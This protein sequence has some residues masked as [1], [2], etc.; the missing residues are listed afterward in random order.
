VKPRLNGRSA[1]GLSQVTSLFSPTHHGALGPWDEILTLA[2][3]V[4]GA[5]LF[6]YLYFTA[7]PPRPDEDDN[8]AAAPEEPPAS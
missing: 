7:R 5:L 8:P 1:I 6:L 2:P 4:T 3:L